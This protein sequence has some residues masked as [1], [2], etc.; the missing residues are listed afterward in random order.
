MVRRRIPRAERKRLRK[1]SK[2]EKKEI[3]RQA[4]AVRKIERGRGLGI[5][6]RLP[7]SERAFAKKKIKQ[8][9]IA[10]LPAAAA[11]I[12]LIPG[13]IP[14]IGTGVV[15]TVTKR[16]LLSL[17][18]A[19]LLSI[20]PG[21][22]LVGETA[23][24]IFRTGQ[25]IP[26]GIAKLKEDKGDIFKI[27]AGLGLTGAAIAAITQ[28]PKIIERIRERRAER[29]PAAQIQVQP[30]GTSTFQQPIGIVEKEQIPEKIEEAPIKPVSPIKIN[31]KPQIDIRVNA[32]GIKKRFINQQINV[33]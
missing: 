28:A 16:P 1:K 10:A 2:A 30:I 21:R 25:K 5:I 20:K 7:P 19:G 4:K 23:E 33:R 31:F 22:Q 12:A 3:K 6:A 24:T 8:I 18:G 14:A 15:R 9:K 26:A 29:A 27:L 13:A 11:T 17:V 32:T